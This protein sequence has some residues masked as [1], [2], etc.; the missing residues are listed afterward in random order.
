MDNVLSVNEDTGECAALGDDAEVLLDALVTRARELF[1]AW[2]T[3]RNGPDLRFDDSEL[4]DLL[5]Q[6]TLDWMGLESNTGPVAWYNDPIAHAEIVRR[7]GSGNIPQY[8]REIR[9]FNP[10]ALH[11]YAEHLGIS[12]QRVEHQY[13]LLTTFAVSG[14]AG[15]GL[16][17]EAAISAYEVR[18]SN[19]LGMS[20]SQATICGSVGG[21]VGAGLS[22]VSVNVES[23]LG[24]GDINAGSADSMEYYGP[25]FFD[26]ALIG[27]LNAEAIN[28]GGI[29][30]SGITFTN[31]DQTLTFNT[32]GLILRVGTDMVGSVSATGGGGICWY[33]STEDGVDMGDP[34]P[35][36]EQS[37]EGEWVS[38]IEAAVFFP[39]GDSSLDGDD[40]ATLQGV[41]SAIMRHESASPG[42]IFQVQVIGRASNQWDGN[43]GDSSP[44]ELNAALAA[45]RAAAVRGALLEGLASVQHDFTEGVIGQS[46]MQSLSRSSSS[47]DPNDNGQIDRSVYVGVSYNT[48]GEEGSVEP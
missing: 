38:L 47:A 2:T 48:C 5:H 8:V 16:V 14:G 28:G 44:Q 1:E 37:R 41:I 45:S 10:G 17:G 31:F 15:E 24:T 9:V 4:Q 39:T 20:W 11:S 26:G 33:W 13:Q 18:Y 35:A 42:D 6:F 40:Q 27:Y 7:L 21:G 22:P 23:S 34:D 3:V 29:S 36:E 43:P 30:I 12:A 25:D 32:S 19:D 46:T